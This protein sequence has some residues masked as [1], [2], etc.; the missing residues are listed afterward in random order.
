M[1]KGNINEMKKGSNVLSKGKR[2]L[3][4][5]EL[6]KVKRQW[7]ENY[8]ELCRTV[9]TPAHDVYVL[10]EQELTTREKALMK[11]LGIYY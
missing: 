11:R 4:N 9:N 8:K 6:K 2:L 1:I 3:L 10:K 7:Q 5:L